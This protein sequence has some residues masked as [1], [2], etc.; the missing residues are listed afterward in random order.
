MDDVTALWKAC[1]NGRMPSD[2]WKRWFEPLASEMIRKALEDW[3]ASSGAALE[4]AAMAMHEVIAHR[5]ENRQGEAPP[6]QLVSAFIEP[7]MEC[8]EWAPPP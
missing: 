3:K 7:L 5:A 4:F 8:G 2:T 1:A 6:R